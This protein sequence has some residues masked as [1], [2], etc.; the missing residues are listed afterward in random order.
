LTLPR[1]TVNKG[2][3]RTPIAQRRIVSLDPMSSCARATKPRPF[4]RPRVALGLAIGGFVVLALMGSTIAGDSDLAQTAT[5]GG[6][7]G[8]VAVLLSTF[9]LMA[10]V[11]LV[12]SAII[13][14]L[15]PI[16]RDRG[17]RMGVA[18][19]VVAVASPLAAG[20]LNTVG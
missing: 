5:S 11:I 7:A 3:P 20:V 12:I 17:R 6:G 9:G 13:V 18:A 1:E 16:I 19:I 2:R 14:A 15:D 8:G 4:I 10:G